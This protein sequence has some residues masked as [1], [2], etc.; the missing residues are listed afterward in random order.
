VLGWLIVCGV[1]LLS[2]LVIWISIGLFLYGWENIAK[3]NQPIKIKGKWWEK[4][5]KLARKGIRVSPTEEKAGSD[6]FFYKL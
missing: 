6:G 1:T 5:T 2:S 4:L 3:R